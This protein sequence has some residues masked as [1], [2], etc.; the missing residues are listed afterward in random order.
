MGI[1]EFFFP[2]A[3]NNEEPK[4]TSK[5]E[6]KPVAKPVEEK[7]TSIW[8][9]GKTFPKKKLIGL[10]GHKDAYENIFTTGKYAEYRKQLTER[11]VEV[12]GYKKNDWET[13][14]KEEIRKIADESG[15]KSDNVSHLLAEALRD[16]LKQ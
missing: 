11:L 8:D 10:V 15:R 1:T 12:L 6:E 16:V 5:V 2:N 14:S 3:K 7:I 13:F 9:G 4:P